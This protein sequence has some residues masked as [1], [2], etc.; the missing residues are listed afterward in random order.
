MEFN[1]HFAME[2]VARVEMIM[3][4][5]LSLRR[6]SLSYSAERKGKKLFDITV[7]SA[8]SRIYHWILW[9]IKKKA[10]RHGLRAFNNILQK[11]QF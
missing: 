7:I 9:A 1:P 11:N 2:F 6:N 10:P 8:R 5:R 4:S 3:R